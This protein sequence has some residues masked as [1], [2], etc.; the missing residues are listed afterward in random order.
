MSPSACS[1]QMVS[2]YYVPGIMFCA[3]DLCVE[4]ETAP[5]A[6]CLERVF[7]DKC[8]IQTNIWA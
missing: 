6:H 3:G 7:G 8:I 5:E 2:A 1:K 4:P